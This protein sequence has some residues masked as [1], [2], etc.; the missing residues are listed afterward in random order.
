MT[1]QIRYETYREIRNREELGALALGI[2]GCITAAFG[3]EMPEDEVNDALHGDLVILA[4]GQAGEVV[5]YATLHR[6]LVSDFKPQ[7]QS[8]LEQFGPQHVGF[9]FGAGVVDQKY[10]GRGIYRDLNR[11]RINELM[12]AGA[13]FFATTTQN[14]RVEKGIAKTLDEF[15][16]LG[17]LKGYEIDRQI[18]PEFFKRRLTSYPIDNSTGPFSVLNIVAG[19]AFSLVFKL[20]PVEQ[21][22]KS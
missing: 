16:E 11:Y 8:Q 2:V 10:Q 9:A 12:V 4:R 15:V 21:L 14:P 7:A 3:Q 1:E 18:M 19:D 13:D 22:T 20:D 6:R 17:L 5:G